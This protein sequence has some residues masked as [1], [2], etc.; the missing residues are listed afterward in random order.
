[1]KELK[2]VAAKQRADRQYPS[3]PKSQAKGLS[4]EE[5]R[6]LQAKILEHSRQQ[7]EKKRRGGKFM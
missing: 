1:M 3:E 4:T 5:K 2:Y 7:F 6:S